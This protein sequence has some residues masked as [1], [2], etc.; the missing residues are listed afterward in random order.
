MF[1]EVHHVLKDDPYRKIAL[2]LQRS[3]NRVQV[4]GLTAMLTYA[5]TRPEIV[6]AKDRLC[7]ELQIESMPHIPKETLQKDGF[8]AGC[9]VETIVRDEVEILE[10]FEADRVVPEKER[11]PHLM[12]KT[13]YNRIRNGSATSLASELLSIVRQLE[14]HCMPFCPNFKSPL[15]KP[16]LAS[17]GQYIHKLTINTTEATALFLYLEHWYEALRME[18]T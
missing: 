4:I 3:E 14:S 5:V 1:D 9:A 13:F 12:H 18:R 11:K 7:E 10:I 17:W 8:H 2:D 16:K 6:A 15:S